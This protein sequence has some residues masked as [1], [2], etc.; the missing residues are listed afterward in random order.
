MP[1]PLDRASGRSFSAA[2]KNVLARILHFFQGNA[3]FAPRL[4]SILRS[5]LTVWLCDVTVLPC[6]VWIRRTAIR[7]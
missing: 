6:R 1:V 7:S 5:D 2:L 4:S 3:S